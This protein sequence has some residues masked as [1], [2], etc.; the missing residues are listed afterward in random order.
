MKYKGL[1]VT[2]FATDYLRAYTT[3]NYC[4]MTEAIR[5]AIPK[6]R[7]IA[8]SYAHVYIDGIAYR[9]PAVAIGIM[10]ALYRKP[11]ER[12]L[13]ETTFELGEPL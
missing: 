10:N 8:P 9:F 4:P 13:V 12:D 11:N 5:R 7:Q 2:I 3:P 6:A 1:E